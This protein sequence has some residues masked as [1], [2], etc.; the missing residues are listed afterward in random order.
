MITTISFKIYKNGNVVMRIKKTKKR[1]LK[2][3]IHV[4]LASCTVH[5]HLLS[6]LA[7]KK[8]SKENKT[9]KMQRKVCPTFSM[10]IL[11]CICLFET[12]NII[13]LL[14][15]PLQK[16]R[17]RKVRW[18]RRQWQRQERRGQRVKA[19]GRRRRGRAVGTAD[20]HWQAVMKE[21]RKKKE[22]NDIDTVCMSTL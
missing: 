7:D 13:S 17:R 18:R 2:I 1:P 10:F 20:H 6:T 15:H 21:G 3:V 12:Q 22:D 11:T 5:S 9:R 4:L 8:E 16:K 14:F 19:Q